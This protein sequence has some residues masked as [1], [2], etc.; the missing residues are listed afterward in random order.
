LGVEGIDPRDDL[1]VIS[2]G[3]PGMAVA[4][5]DTVGFNNPNFD[6][7]TIED[8]GNV[9]ALKWRSYSDQD[10][11]LA[12][13]GETSVQIWDVST[14]VRTATVTDHAYSITALEWMAGRPSEILASSSSGIQLFDLRLRFPHVYTYDTSVDGSSK[15]TPAAKLQLQP[16]A[17]LILA[18]ALPRRNMVA[19]WDLRHSR[20]PF[21]TM[22]HVAVKGMQ[23]CPS[24]RNALATGGADGLRLWNIQSGGLRNHVVTKSPVNTLTWFLDRTD[25]MAGFDCCL[26]VYQI[27]SD[28]TKIRKLEQWTQPRVGP[29]VAVERG[30]GEN[31]GR[32]YSLHCESLDGGE[33]LICWE[34]FQ[35]SIK[36]KKTMSCRGG[37]YPR[38]TLACSPVIR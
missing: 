19:L 29:V 4:M 33:A 37:E 10:T 12:V 9:S 7:L 18:A 38:N 34:P 31:S 21:Q 25:L 36:A 26:A 13:G 30:H 8:M 27:R 6:F 28:F 5:W 3:P 23:F 20:T 22:E 17:G 35:R 11:T 15:C 2:F 1:H 32:V 24:H 14:G 16:D